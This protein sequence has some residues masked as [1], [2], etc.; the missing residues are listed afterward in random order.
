MNLRLIVLILL[1]IPLSGN[2][3]FED[4][5]ADLDWGRNYKE[6]SSTY[7]SQVIHTGTNGVFAVREKREGMVS[8]A[9][10]IYLE[11][12]NADLEME[13]S[14]KISLKTKGKTRDFEAVFHL[15]DGFYLFSSFYNQAHENRYLFVQQIDQKRLLP[16]KDMQMIGE[17]PGKGKALSRGFDFRFS[18][19]SSKML[20]YNQ[21]PQKSQ[22]PERFHLRVFDDGLN[23][24]WSR[25][26][27]MPYP[28]N[29]F[30]VE[31]Y[32]VDETGNVYLLGVL[33]KDGSRSRRGGKPNYEYVMLM[34]EEGTSQAQ[35]VEIDPGDYFITDLTFRIANN[36]DLVC[37][38]FYSL[39]ET[40]TIK[41][42]CYFRIDGEDYSVI[43]AD[44]E[45]FDFQ[46][47]S[48]FITDRKADRLSRRDQEDNLELYQYGL[49]RLILRSDGG[50]LLVAEQYYRETVNFYDY[51]GVS[52]T[53]NYYHYNDLI[54]V[55]ISPQGAIEWATRVPKRQ[56]TV[57]DGGFYS[58]YSMAV[59]RSC[60]YFVFNDNAR[61][62][63]GTRRP[64]ELQNFNGSRSVISLAAV[65]LNGEI[66]IYPL[67]E[68]RET[69]VISRPKMCKQ[70]GSREMVIYG[71]RNRN[72][73]FARLRFE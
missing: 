11:K 51:R 63:Q 60:L 12:Y 14:Q 43:Q 24:M 7:L 23:L 62:F 13:K 61:N 1:V 69:N 54:V 48:E 56:V 8:Y 58:S 72:Y 71:E 47:I 9:N 3:Q 33:F 32:R 37:A 38:G 34:F 2:G 16:S 35:Q 31:Q 44:L 25:K 46:F 59:T 57:D 40:Y 65:K 50:A 41:G 70:T 45:P 36:G 17:S 22:E 4:P 29:T 5:P 52:R 10:A 42:I 21:I 53:R 20:I 19:D 15:N 55:N 68:N 26:V 27:E 67:Q 64:N 18:A 73:R 30:R 6:P 28:D 39:K 66:D 49:D